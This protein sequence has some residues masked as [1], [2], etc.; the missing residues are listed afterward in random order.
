MYRHV[1]SCMYF[2][3]KGR[4]ALR[5]SL[6]TFRFLTIDRELQEIGANQAKFTPFTHILRE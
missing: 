5:Q 6:T 2:P 3:G 1:L 4:E